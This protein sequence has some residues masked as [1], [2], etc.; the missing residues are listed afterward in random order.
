MIL[1]IFLC[2]GYCWLSTSYCSAP[3]K[4][5]GCSGPRLSLLQ[6]GDFA[7]TEEAI[8]YAETGVD[9]GDETCKNNGGCNVWV[10]QEEYKTIILY[11]FVEKKT[12]NILLMIAH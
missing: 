3:Y 4:S 9:I 8:I 2:S 7:K 5:H 11:S 12:K 10:R 6:W 1:W